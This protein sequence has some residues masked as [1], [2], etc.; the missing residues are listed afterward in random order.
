VPPPTTRN[1]LLCL[2]F[3]EAYG[4]VGPSYEGCSHYKRKCQ[5][6]APCCDTF[7]PC[8]FC[9]D[10]QRDE[11]EKDVKKRHNLDRKAVK[12]VKCMRCGEVQD[13]AKECKSCGVVMGFYFCPVCNLYDDVDKKQFHCDKCTICRVG[14]AEKY[15]DKRQLFCLKRFD[16]ILHF[17]CA[18]IS[19]AIA[20]TP[21]C[22][23]P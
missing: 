16:F 15:V 23:Q 21:A 14:G 8:R 7:Y 20:V 11:A 9:H 1:Y 13:P 5:L 19:T 12:K 22:L 18:V 6:L 17:L 2:S 4:A 3:S 10:E